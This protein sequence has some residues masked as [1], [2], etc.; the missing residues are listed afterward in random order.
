MEGVVGKF[1]RVEFGADVERGN[2][3]GAGMLKY[4]RSVRKIN[5]KLKRKADKKMRP[6]DARR[7]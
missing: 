7:G 1:G 6:E 2:E 5:I 4:R 3:D